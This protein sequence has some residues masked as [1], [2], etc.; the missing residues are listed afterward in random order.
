MAFVLRNQLHSRQ[1][2]DDSREL[3][4][5]KEEQPAFYSALSAIIAKRKSNTAPVS[6]KFRDLLDSVFM[7]EAMKMIAEEGG[8]TEKEC[9]DDIAVLHKHRVRTVA[10]LRVLEPADIEKLG[11]SP[12]VARYLLRIKA[13]RTE[14]SNI[15]SNVSL[16]N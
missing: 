15:T 6:D 3:A 9:D 10:N 2:L 5:L 7:A 4:A 12:V 11:L 14:S 13:G 1:T 8:F 16:K